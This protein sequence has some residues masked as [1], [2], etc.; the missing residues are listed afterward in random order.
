LG[1]RI[2]ARNGLV[3]AGLA[4]WI[5]AMPANWSTTAVAAQAPAPSP[6]AANRA[7]FE[8]YCLTCHT[9]RQKE[10]GT[11]PI[12]LDTLDLSRI[13]ADA[14]VWEKVVLKMRAG[15][16]PPAGVP[17]PDKATHDGFASWI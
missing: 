2:S 7:T 12:A 11:V 3:C 5:A 10:R 8:R 17:R 15:V 14:A 9:T 4:A 13:P 6:V 1:V 16:M